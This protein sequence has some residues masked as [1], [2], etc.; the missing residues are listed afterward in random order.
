MPLETRLRLLVLHDQAY[1]NGREVVV[2]ER[3]VPTVAIACEPAA[4]RSQSTPA[5]LVPDGPVAL[6]PGAGAVDKTELLPPPPQ[7]A[8]IATAAHANAVCKSL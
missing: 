8:N 2:V 5:V 1:W 3:S 6:P 7:A 4:L